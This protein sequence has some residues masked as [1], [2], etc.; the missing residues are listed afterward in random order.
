MKKTILIYLL[1]LQPTLT[2]ASVWDDTQVWDN[3]WEEKYSQWFE[4]KVNPQFFTEGTYGGI[5]TDCAD[6]AFFARAIFSY[7]NKL[8]FE[9]T[10]IDN[11]KLVSN[12]TSS[13]DDI[14]EGLPRLKVFFER[15]QDVVS[16]QSI[17]LDTYPVELRRPYVRP[18]IIVNHKAT[19]FLGTVTHHVDMVKDINKNGS[20]TFISSTLPAAIRELTLSFTL[21]TQPEDEKTQ[22]QGFRT[23]YWPQN[24]S[25]KLT[26]NMGYSN[27]QYSVRAATVS[28]DGE[29]SNS[30]RSFS[31]FENLL[32]DRLNVQHSSLQELED[33][34][35]TEVCS[36]FAARVKIIKLAEEFRKNKNGVCMNAKEYDDYSTPTR[37]ARLR[38][39]T[40]RYLINYIGQDQ[41]Q[42]SSSRNTLYSLKSKLNANCP[43]QEIMNGYSMSF[44]EFLNI[45]SENPASL[46]SNPNVSIESRWG[47]R[48]ETTSCPEY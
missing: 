9:Y 4:E 23:W 6:A 43:A 3:S 27:E 25:K 12:K 18:G 24:R 37:D 42:G 36:Q 45:M 46:S 41:N 30:V 40:E 16:T 11:L 2:F 33:Q 47:L 26:E 28:F 39:I 35:Q 14:P 32:K 22:K 1:L 20:I 34:A 7:E 10:R 48:H 17:H 31:E 8:P 29:R 21:K 44:Y 15:M 13:L 38:L 5:K 19:G